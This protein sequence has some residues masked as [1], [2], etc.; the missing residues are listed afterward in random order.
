MF[1]KLRLRLTLANLS[2][3]LQVFIIVFTGVYITMYN[4]ITNQSQ[5]LMNLLTFSTV[6]GGEPQ[7]AKMLGLL[8][9]QSFIIAEISS[10]GA[11]TSYRIA[12]SLPG[13][14]KENIVGLVKSVLSQNTP[15]RKRFS[16]YSSINP[17]IGTAMVI[18]TDAQP[19]QSDSG[20]SYRTRLIRTS[21][22]HLTMI[23]IN[24]NYEKSLLSSLR[25]NLIAIALAG[26]GLVFGASLFMAGR[27]V[28]PIKAAWE[29]QKSFVA[30]A[31]HELRTPLSV[32][33]TNLELVM[34]NIEETVLSQEKWLD[35]ISAENKHMTKLVND[36]LLLARIDS[37]QKLLEFNGFSMSSAVEE[38]VRPFIP[39]ATEKTL[40]FNYHIKPDVN[41]I[42]DE[43]RGGETAGVGLGLSIAGWIVK[44]HHGIIKVE[45]ELGKGTSF[46]II[47]SKNPKHKT[48]S[49]GHQN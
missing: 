44:E 35:N 18:I 3:V 25:L 21:D 34:G 15:T 13:L 12:P 9:N 32:M 28:K 16:S 29:K 47:F 22:D 7:N 40:A 31:S 41:F 23:F 46:K 30:D 39:V 37:D 49:I 45:S 20:I 48:V 6:S 17:L 2:V 14:E 38:A 10:L 11:V 4:S 36:L 33:Q 19:V 26:L 5:Q 43:S 27:T 42:G 1:D 8:G 24:I